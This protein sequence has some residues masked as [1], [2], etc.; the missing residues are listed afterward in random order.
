MID[1]LT[2][3]RK[4]ES[5]GILSKHA[6][7]ITAAISNQE[8]QEIKLI[9]NDIDTIKQDIRRVDSRIEE[10]NNKLDTKIE[11]VSNKLDN[12]FEKL[13]DKIE[14]VNNKLDNKFEKLDDKIEEANNKVG[15]EIKELNNKLD[16]KFDKQFKWTISLISIM[17]GILATIMTLLKFLS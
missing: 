3:S 11:E 1:T 17:T 9:K 7:A 16:N 4:L 6:E 14:E 12:K 15:S 2:A 10:V 8:N 13:D 5:S